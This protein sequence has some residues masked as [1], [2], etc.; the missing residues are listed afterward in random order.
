MPR[1]SIDFEY[2]DKM[3][4]L[5]YNA[6]VVKRLD[7]SGVI[8]DMFNGARPLTATEDLFVA[9]FEANHPTVSIKTRQKMY[10]DLSSNNEGESLVECL[11]ELINDV[12]DE[13]TPKG[14]IQWRMNRS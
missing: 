8:A 11:L 13:M 7:K 1:A 14:N 10:K 2:E 9:A 6:D 3:Y 4:K 12:V 5:T